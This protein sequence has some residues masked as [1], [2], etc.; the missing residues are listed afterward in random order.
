LEQDPQAIRNKIQSTIATLQ[1]RQKDDGSFGLYTVRSR[2][3]RWVDVY[4]MDFLTVAKAKGHYVPDQLFDKGMENLEMIAASPYRNAYDFHSQ[5]YAI[6][7]LTKNE[8]ITTSFLERIR[9]EM[10]RENV[11]CRVPRYPSF[12]QVHTNFCR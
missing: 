3:N 7:V 2:S 11:R 4:I 12:S 6:Y 1:A 9:R 5:A 8:V 10:D